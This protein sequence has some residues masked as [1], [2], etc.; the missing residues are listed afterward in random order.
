MSISILFIHAPSTKVHIP[1]LLPAAP[2]HVS[3]SLRSCGAETGLAAPLLLGGGAR[4]ARS[5]LA[6]RPPAARQSLSDA[7]AVLANLARAPDR[8]Q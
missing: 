1:V 7:A 2:C 8:D 6:R 4:T 5:A 3:D